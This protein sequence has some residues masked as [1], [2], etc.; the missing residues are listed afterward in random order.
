METNYYPLTKE[1]VQDLIGI[2]IEFT[3]EGYNRDYKGTAIINSVDFSK[4]N[5]IDCD[6]LSG[7]D[8]K[9]AFLDDHGLET[10]DQGESFHVTK[11]CTSFSYSDGYREVFVNKI[12][13]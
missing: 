11:I 7:D 9:Y 1:N 3:A 4:R 8:L 10:T 5:P 6:C 2:K 12:D 13:Q